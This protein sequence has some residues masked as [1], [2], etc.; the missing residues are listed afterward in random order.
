MVT[1]LL[2]I[3]AGP[4]E[5]L[6]SG[7]SCLHSSPTRRGSCHP[8]FQVRKLRPREGPAHGYHHTAGGTEPGFKPR[9][10]HSRT[11]ARLSVGNMGV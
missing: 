2:F 5:P 8:V 3:V 11:W 4:C 1:G 7:L 9:Q 10:P 6:V